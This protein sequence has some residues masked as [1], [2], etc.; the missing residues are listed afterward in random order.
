MPNPGQA[1]PNG[2]DPSFYWD[3]GFPPYQRPPLLTPSFS[4]SFQAT[5][6]P[7]SDMKLCRLTTHG[8]LLSRQKPRKLCVR[9]DLFRLE[10]YAST[11]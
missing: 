9:C 7:A 11:Q 5:W 8:T 1:S 2:Y 6:F 10:G 3:K 4:T